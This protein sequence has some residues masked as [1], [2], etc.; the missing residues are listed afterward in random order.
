MF[1]GSFL[2]IFQDLIIKVLFEKSSELIL[3]ILIYYYIDE[4]CCFKM[5][6]KESK[7]EKERKNCFWW[8]GGRELKLV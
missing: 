1:E 6:R 3:K 7:R 4:F 2:G 5:I 8:V